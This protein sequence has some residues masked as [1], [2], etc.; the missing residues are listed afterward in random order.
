RSGGGGPSSAARWW[1]GRELRSVAPPSS[2]SATLPPQAGGDHTRLNTLTTTPEAWRHVFEVN[3]FSTIWLAQGLVTELATAHGAIVNVTSI[4]GSRVHPFAG[5]AYATSKAALAALTREMAADMG[6][7]G[8]RVNAIAPGEIDTAILSPGTEKIVES[9]PMR[10]LGAPEEVA[11]A[12]YYLCTEQSS[13]V[14]GAEL[15]INGGQH[16]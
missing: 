16:V 6:P 12:I 8:I 13:Y 10:R 4:A 9:I 7:L 14:T 2:P 15:H 3:F 5:S 11:K 1:R